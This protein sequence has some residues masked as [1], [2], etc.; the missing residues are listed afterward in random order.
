MVALRD[1]SASPFSPR[2]IE[3]RDE[4]RAVGVGVEGGVVG[5]FEGSQL[6]SGIHL[7]AAVGDPLEQIGKSYGRRNPADIVRRANYDRQRF[8]G[9]NQSPV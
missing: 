2:R 4:F 1:G 5:I 9:H 3:T 8:P 6:A 7:H